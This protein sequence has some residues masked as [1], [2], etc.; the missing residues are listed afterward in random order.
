MDRRRS[1]IWA[2]LAA[3]TV[4]GMVVSACQQENGTQGGQ[5]DPEG[6]LILPITAEP[7]SIDPQVESFVT[8]IGITML[9]FDALMAFDPDTLRPIPGSAREMKVSNDGL[10]YTFILKDGLKYSDGVDVKAKDYEYAFKRLCDPD[11]AG[12]YQ[13]TGFIVVGCEE[14]AHADPAADSP[15]KLQELRNKVGVK[16]IDDKTIEYKIKEKA[17][18]FPSLMGMWI[19]VPTR[20]DKVKAGGDRWT[21]PEHFIGNGLFKLTE[22]R[23][24]EKLVFERNENHNPK[25]KLKKIT[26]PVMAEQAV[27]FAAYQNGDI[28]FVAITGPERT[29]VEGNAELS[30]QLVR[31]PGSCT[32]Y[33]GFNTQKPPFDDPNVRLAFSKAYDRDQYVKDIRQGLGTPNASFIP[34]GLP[35]YDAEDAAQKFDA[36]AAKQLLTQSRYGT[37]IPPVK[38]T[39]SSTQRNKTNAEWVIGQWKQHLGVD[40]PL[41]P[42]DSTAFTRLVKDKATTPQLFYLS[43]CA[44]YADQYNWLYDAYTVTLERTNWKN[45]QFETLVRQAAG[46]QDPARRTD[47]YKQ[48]QRIL[49]KDAPAGFQFTTTDWVLVKPWVQGHKLTPID[50]GFSY[51]TLANVFV[52][53][54]APKRN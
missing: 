29:T 33:F 5:I 16:A 8:E 4:L 34:P 37:A 47:L 50:F 52:T 18:Y 24:N 53:T 20:E 38:F 49:T 7:D 39:Y 35:G 17:S 46:E 30:K 12:E 51:N 6:E 10:T 3:L 45:Q 25:A 48:A 9:V 40:I 13:G 15:A 43:W 21:E 28:D 36:P 23:H 2:I 31:V 42:V 11:V 14:Y 19:G 44:D 27:R 1:G 22:W 26:K 41:D 54:A 32:F